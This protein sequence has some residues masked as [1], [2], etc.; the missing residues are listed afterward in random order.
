MCP[1]DVSYCYYLFH[2]FSF[3]PQS[4]LLIT[5]SGRAVPDFLAVSLNLCAIID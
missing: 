1:L 2:F 5:Y 3:K 4:P